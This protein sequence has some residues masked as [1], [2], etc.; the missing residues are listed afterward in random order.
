MTE[1]MFNYIYK[2]SLAGQQ[3][4]SVITSQLYRFQFRM[5]KVNV[6]QVLPSQ[7]IYKDAK[8]PSS[9]HAWEKFTVVL[10]WKRWS[11]DERFIFVCT[12]FSLTAVR[13]RFVKTTREAACFTRQP[14]MASMMFWKYYLNIEVCHM[15]PNIQLA[16]LTMTNMPPFLGYFFSRPRKGDCL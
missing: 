5:Y 15:K 9:I 6:L 2:M 1:D 8:Q 12:S 13:I 11:G 16:F 7:A 4:F 3:T 14:K 10:N